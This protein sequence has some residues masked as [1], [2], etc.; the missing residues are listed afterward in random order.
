M[1]VKYQ[2]TVTETVEAKW[3]VIEIPVDDD[4]MPV[5]YP[6]RNG[7]EWS[8]WVDVETGEIDEWPH[9][10]PPHQFAPKVRYSGVY[11]LAN[12][13]RRMIRELIEEYVPDC[14]PNEY[15][16]YLTLSVDEDGKITNWCATPENVA[17]SF[18]PIEGD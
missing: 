8:V 6:F 5:D 2:K 15:G 16:D 9:G 13:K 1:Q 17:S 4:D 12:A 3:I 10:I 7:G 14:L 11:I 18:W